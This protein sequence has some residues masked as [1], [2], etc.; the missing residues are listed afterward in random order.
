MYNLFLKNILKKLSI[1]IEYSI[2]VNICKFMYIL[3][4]FKLHIEL[5]K[6]KSKLT[7]VLFESN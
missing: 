5:G 7:S 4:Y 2:S 3:N 6:Y 1:P